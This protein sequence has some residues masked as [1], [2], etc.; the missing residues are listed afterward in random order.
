LTPPRFLLTIK[1]AL[2][3]AL[4]DAKLTLIIQSK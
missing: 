2:I 3:A 4:S 1:I